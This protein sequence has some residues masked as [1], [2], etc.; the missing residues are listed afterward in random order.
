MIKVESKITRIG[1][2]SEGVVFP[3]DIR[4]DEKY[5][6]KEVKK[7]IVEIVGNKIV[8]RKQRKKSVSI[9]LREGIKKI[10]RRTK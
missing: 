1:G 6:F 8:V 2:T 10:K 9:S 7:V 4:K 3:S 5:P